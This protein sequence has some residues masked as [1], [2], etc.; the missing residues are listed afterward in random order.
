MRRT[1][2]ESHTRI[3]SVKKSDTKYR[4]RKSKRASKNNLRK[5]QDMKSIRQK[6]ALNW[7]GKLLIHIKTFKK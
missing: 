6:S 3:N 5:K 2:Y 1:G 4:I 7:I